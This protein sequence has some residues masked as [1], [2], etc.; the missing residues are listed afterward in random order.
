MS[1][2]RFE[3]ILRF[4]HLADSEKQPQRGEL[5]F[6][7]LYKLRP[8]LNLLLPRFRNC[9]TPGQYLSIDES[10]IAF[11]GRLSFLQ[12]LPKKP[13]KWGMKAWVLADAKT[14]YTWAWKLYTGKEGDRGDKGLAHGVTMELVD[15]ERLQGKGYVIVTDNFYSSPALFRELQ[16]NGFGACGTTRRDRRGIPSSVRDAKLQRGETISSTDDGILSL[17]WRDKRDVT[18]LSTYHD[19]SMVTKN[20]R[21]RTAQGGVEDILKPKVVEDY[22]K[23]MGGVDKSKWLFIHDSQTCCPLEVH[24]S[25]FCIFTYTFTCTCIAISMS[26]YIYTYPTYR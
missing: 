5:G 9:Y 19:D 3:L 7:K 17:K 26:L 25:L 16:Q 20:R 10:M 13:H 18:M 14:G 21:S 11:K 2:R 22:N 24:Q 12:Y 23:N 8:L 4:L 6:D 1:S 15:D